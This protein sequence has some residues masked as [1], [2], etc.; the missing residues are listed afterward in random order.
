MQESETQ[1]SYRQSVSSGLDRQNSTA[2]H[3]EFANSQ[4]DPFWE[5]SGKE[6]ELRQQ[7]KILRVPEIS[8]NELQ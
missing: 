6:S 7:L 4:E 2:G 1:L 5:P 8:M 3:Y